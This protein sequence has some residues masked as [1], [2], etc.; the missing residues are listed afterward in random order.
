VL[1]SKEKQIGEHTY[2]A[3]QLP[4]TKAHKLLIRIGKILGP[5]IGGGLDGVK[6]SFKDD[7]A[8]AIGRA[9]SGLFE[10]ATPD[11]VDA[12]LKEFVEYSEVDGKPLKSCFDL[13]FAGKL[14]DMYLWFAFALEVNYSDFFGGFKQASAALVAAVTDR[15]KPPSTSSGQ[16]GDSL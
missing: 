14:A 1:E 11:E 16:P 6:G 10:R 13:H 15:L 7:A 4:A 12:I 8:G 3:R 2:L 9:V 5:A